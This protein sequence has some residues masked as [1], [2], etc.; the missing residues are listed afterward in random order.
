MT[1][2]VGLLATELEASPE[3][4]VAD[5]TE[6]AGVA[7]G[8]PVVPLP[9]LVEPAAVEF[10]EVGE[11]WTGSA[12]LVVPVAFGALTGVRD[13]PGVLV[14]PVVAVLAMPFGDVAGPAVVV[15]PI[16]GL[17]E[18][19]EATGGTEPVELVVAG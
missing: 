15:E 6:F 11:V 13:P 12:G 4:A 14:D 3:P 9:V 18:G 5:V 1:G 16:V 19:L 17:L 2:L 8:A 10:A 7:V